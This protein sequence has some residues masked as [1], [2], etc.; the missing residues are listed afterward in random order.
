MEWTLTKEFVHS[1]F[2]IKYKGKEDRQQ[3]Q[4]ENTNNNKRYR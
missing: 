1:D 3:K 4:I 2:G